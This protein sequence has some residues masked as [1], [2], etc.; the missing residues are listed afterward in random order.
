MPARREPAPRHRAGTAVL[1][2]GRERRTAILDAATAVLVEDGYGQ[3]SLRK[4]AA[5]AGIRLGNLQY[6]YATKADVVRALLERW[7][8]RARDAIDARMAAH[9]ASPAA[10]LDA[11]LDGILA[12]AEPAGSTRVFWELWAL[13]AHDPDV[14]TA[15]DGF[16]ADYAAAAGT[17]LRA[18]NPVLDAATARRRGALLA[19]LFEGLS[20]YRRRSAPHR[21]PPALVDEVRAAVRMLATAP[22]A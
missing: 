19:S 1:A 21:L 16:Y 17:L 22:G 12:D 20:L 3:L 2:K 5:R 9:G 13:A 8:V 4:I 14:A 7:L 10:R 18:V 6:Y 15:T 11:A